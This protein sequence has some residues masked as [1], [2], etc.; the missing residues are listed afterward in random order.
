MSSTAHDKYDIVIAGAGFA[1]SL[2]ALVLHNLGFKVCLVE[3]GKHPRFAIGESSTP[4]GDIMLRNLSAKYNLPWLHDFSRYGTWQQSHP[5]IVCGIKRGFSFYKHYQGE[6]FTTDAKHKN[7]LLVAASDDNMLSD[8]NWLRADFD[9][10]L[11]NKVKEAGINYFDLA[12]IV[13]GKWNLSWEFNITR[14]QQSIKILASFFIDATGNP[15]LLYKLL[16]IKSSSRDFLTNSFALFSHFQEIP[17]WTDMLKKAGISDD[18]YPYDPDLSALHHILDEG[19][20]WV[21][22]FNDERTSLGF[23]LHNTESYKEVQTEKIWDDLLVKYPTIQN[24]FQP[25]SLSSLPGKIVRSGRLQRKIS[26]CF[27]S[28]WVA[29]PHTAGFVDPLFSTG[30]AYSLSGI[31]QIIPVIT[32]YWKDET[33]LLHHL[34]EYELAVFDEL[35]LIDYLIAGCY[36]TMTNFELFN[37]WSMLYFAITINYES[38]RLKGES[39]GCY[40]HADQPDIKDLVQKSYRDLSKITDQVSPL[41]EDK[42]NIKGFTD[43]IRERIKPFNT[44]GLMDPSTHNMYRHTAA[45]L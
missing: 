31:E 5:E 37:T 41:K 2:T 8:T 16:S 13:S 25:A 38:Y 45:K 7:E 14:F 29:L 33:Q 22:R 43:L 32:K 26:N 9:S 28:G 12:E 36:K 19:W 34:K 4:L 40:L 1:G 3:K 27:G 39:S 30:I 23:V 10:F 11:V 15:A 44:A 42:Q 24:I 20:L 18:D 17:H 21:L 6:E 35:K